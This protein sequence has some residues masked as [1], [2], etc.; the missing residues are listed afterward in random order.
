MSLDLDTPR[1]KKTIEFTLEQCCDL[2]SKTQV[3]VLE[4]LAAT[5][6][7]QK[8][9]ARYSKKRWQRG[10]TYMR[11]TQH[12]KVATLQALKRL[13]LIETCCH[14]LHGADLIRI[15]RKGVEVL[16]Q[17]KGGVIYA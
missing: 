17:F 13:G 15:S 8:A 1:P 7:R 9:E 2:V 4:H 11:P 16:E 5:A 14:D 3:A 10:W 6:V 12:V